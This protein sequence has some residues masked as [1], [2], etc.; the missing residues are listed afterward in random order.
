MRYRYWITLGASIV[1]GL[2]FVTS[3]AGKLFGQSA[4][5]L[6]VQAISFLPPVFTIIIGYWLPWVEMVLGLLL[7]AGVV[8]QVVALVSTVLIAAFIFHNSWMIS[9]G[10]G[11][12]PC[13]CLG[14]LDRVLGGDLSTTGAL[15]IDIGL[16]ILAVAVYFGYQGKL[17]NVRPW[18]LRR[19]RMANDSLPETETHES[20]GD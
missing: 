4:F 7:I 9:Q 11:N 12:E 17:F 8:T 5:L 15:Y 13:A 14:I 10:L 18:F 20:T 2:V 3:G 16:L 19:G 1:L 6:N